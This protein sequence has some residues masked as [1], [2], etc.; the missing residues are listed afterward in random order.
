MD[1]LIFT[2][3]DIPNEVEKIVREFPD[4]VGNKITSDEKD[5]Y[6]HGIMDTLAVLRGL[7]D[8]DEEPVVYIS[9]IEMQEM[10]IE[11]LEEIFLK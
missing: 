5:A 8:L 3:M 11:E 1:E 4:K 10:G 2:A 6:M 9:G 7:L